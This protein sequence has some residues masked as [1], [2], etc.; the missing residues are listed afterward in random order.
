MCFVCFYNKK[1]QACLYL[2]IQHLR[3][4]KKWQNNREEGGA[5]FSFGVVKSEESIPFS[6]TS[7]LSIYHLWKC[8]FS[9]SK[10]N[11]HDEA[12]A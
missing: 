11:S 12:L 1:I 7:L 8:W 3:F 4:W 5:I 10:Y 6:S 9:V 2:W